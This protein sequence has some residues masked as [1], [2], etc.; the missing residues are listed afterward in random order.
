MS[1]LKTFKTVT[2][3]FAFFS[4]AA[5][6]F[7]HE[8]RPH[9]WPDLWKS[10]AWEPAVVISL[11]LTAWLYFFGLSRLW[12]ATGTDRGV[13][14]WEAWSYAAGWLALFI[15]LVSPLHSWG[16]VLFSAHM[17]QHEVLM[18]VSAPLLVLG[19]PIVPFLHALPLTWARR[20]TG[21][22]RSNLWQAIWRFLTIP[23]IAWL[24][25]AIVLWV[26]HIP[27]L[28]DATLQSQSIH[29]IQHIS[30]LFSAL[31]FWWALFRAKN[32]AFNYGL[33]VL[34][35]FTTALHSG[36]L[37]ALLTFAPTS[38]YPAYANLTESWGLTPLQ[39]QQLGGL[40]MWIPSGVVYIVAGLAVFA[41]WLSESEKRVL[42]G[43]AR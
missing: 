40:I 6:L 29:A 19:R 7:A 31:L 26:W 41:A 34:Y 21:L 27:S 2:F 32:S 4:C 14:K 30:F 33:G 24:L 12:K 3:V 16:Q 5:P 37:G 23:F 36:L 11:I 10:W 39:D 8:G 28:F 13:H 38:W 22:S 43:E 25:H 1:V 42:R 15:A 35:L 17:T 9:N 20:A 18:L